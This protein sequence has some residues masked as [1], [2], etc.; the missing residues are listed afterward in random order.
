MYD[1]KSYI[2]ERTGGRRNVSEATYTNKFRVACPFLLSTFDVPG[3]DRN[4]LADSIKAPKETDWLASDENF[5]H[6]ISKLNPKF[7]KVMR[8]YYVEEM[9]QQQIAEI[10]GDSPS[11]ISLVMKKAH[12]FLKE[13]IERNRR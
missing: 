6:L 5:Y 7:R 9:Q 3:S 13:I 11:Y 12:K 8:L 1:M 2:R 4:T 10:T